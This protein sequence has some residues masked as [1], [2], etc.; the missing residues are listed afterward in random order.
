MPKRDCNSRAFGSGNFEGSI[1]QIRNLRREDGG[2]VDRHDT[3]DKW[4]RRPFGSTSIFAA[5]SRAEIV[6]R[7]VKCS[8]AP[9][10]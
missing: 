7:I 4:R 8:S 6:V 3:T 9:E 1:I 10:S 5:A 2:R